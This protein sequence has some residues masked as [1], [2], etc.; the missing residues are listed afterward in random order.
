MS[1]PGMKL[2]RFVVRCRVEAGQ[3]EPTDAECGEA[4]W[5]WCPG[6]VTHHSFRTKAYKGET[7]AVGAGPVPIWTFDGNMESPT[8]SPSLLYTGIV[9]PK[10]GKELGRCHLFL[11]AGVIE[12]L[13]DCS[14]ELAGKRVPL[15]EAPRSGDTP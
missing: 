8:F 6:C 14:H 7:R 13:G 12:F 9:S 15:G 4:F 2:E 3:L 5:F 10:T 11:R 1:G